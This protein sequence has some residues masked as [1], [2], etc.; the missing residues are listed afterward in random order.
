MLWSLAMNGGSFG[1]MFSGP[2]ALIGTRAA[3]L[4]YSG[5]MFLMMNI[6]YYYILLI[7][8]KKGQKDKDI[9][10]NKS[11]LGNCKN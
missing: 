3:G 10:K 7:K 8:V 9:A 4:G 11:I 2:D 1:M 5:M 6:P